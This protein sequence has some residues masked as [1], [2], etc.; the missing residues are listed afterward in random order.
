MALFSSSAEVT[1]SNPPEKNLRD[2]PTAPYQESGQA[3]TRQQWVDKMRTHTDRY[4]SPSISEKDRQRILDHLE[5]YLQI[6]TPTLRA[7]GIGQ[8]QEAYFKDLT[9]EGKNTFRGLARG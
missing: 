6:S 7:K 4:F 3:L 8:L 5:G 9:D 2:I 1:I